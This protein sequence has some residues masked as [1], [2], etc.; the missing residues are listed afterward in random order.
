MPFF[1]TRAVE[2]FPIRRGAHASPRAVS[3]ALAG[4]RLEVWERSGYGIPARPMLLAN[5]AR[6]RAP[7]HAGARVLPLSL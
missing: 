7:R 3:G 6:G 5:G 1:T 2:N 4:N